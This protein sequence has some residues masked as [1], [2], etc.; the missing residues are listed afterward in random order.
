MKAFLQGRWLGH[1]LHPI[2]THFP[3]ALIPATAIFDI[4]ALAT[5]DNVWVKAATI[6][7]LIALIGAALAAIV[8]L[9]EWI[10]IPK[11][12]HT[13]ASTANAHAILN[14]VAVV[15][16]IISLIMH[17]TAWDDASV[18]FLAFLLDVAAVLIVAFSGYLGGKLVYDHH[19]GVGRDEATGHPYLRD[20]TATTPAAQQVN[21]P[22]R[23]TLGR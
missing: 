15:G 9:A 6:T 5:S 11:E 17:V 4:L 10:D 21:T 20:T 14:V 8:G 16:G 22:Q 23:I 18:P 2:F 19:L 12:A 13:T 1:P 3:V 7:L